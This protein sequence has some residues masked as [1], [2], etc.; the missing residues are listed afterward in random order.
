M[1]SKRGPNWTVIGSAICMVLAPIAVLVVLRGQLTYALDRGHATITAKELSTGHTPASHNVTVTEGAVDAEYAIA[2]RR[3]QDGSVRSTS[4]FFPVRAKG[5]GKNDPIGILAMTTVGTPA[6]GELEGI[7]RNAGGQGPPGAVVAKLRQA[8][9]VVSSDA[10]LVE[11]GASPTNDAL[12]LAFYLAIAIFL[13]GVSV[14]VNVSWPTERQEKRKK[15]AAARIAAFRQ[16]P[17]FADVQALERRL[18]DAAR[19]YFPA[20]TE[21][22]VSLYA[23]RHMGALN[24]TVAIDGEDQ[25]APPD[26]V[27]LFQQICA[28]YKKNKVPIE[29]VSYTCEFHDD[30][31]WKMS[32]GPS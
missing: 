6:D 20:D 30:E 26:V 31:G 23:R 22:S 28:I 7:L 19:R 2:L 12:W 1:A 32:G 27:A 14:V 18:F 3:L 8:G 11:I 17:P 24:T 15:D 10:M 21:Q 29:I 5:A 13:P 25:P 16:T 4:N 9:L